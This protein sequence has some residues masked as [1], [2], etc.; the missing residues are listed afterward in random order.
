MGL[1]PQ[2]YASWVQ[3][4]LA[5][6]DQDWLIPDF[7]PA[8]SLTIIAGRPKY[9]AKSWISY[10]MAWAVSSGLPVGPFRPSRKVPCLYIDLEGIAKEAAKRVQLVRN[11][12]IEVPS[13]DL[14]DMWQAH[15]QL[16]LL[17]NAAHLDDLLDLVLTHRIKC[18]FI[19]TF[20]KA[21]TGADEN[22]ARD[23]GTVLLAIDRLKRAGVAVVLVHHL[24]K[25]F[26]QEG[27][28]SID[29]TAG[30][31]GSGALEGG[32]DHILSVTTATVDDVTQDYWVVGGKFQPWEAYEIDWTFKKDAYA[33]LAWQK[34]RTLPI[35][36]KPTRQPFRG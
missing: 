2:K 27:G 17:S 33:K 12:G 25:A 8:A 23:I 5:N 13:V 9:G 16:F 14:M 24:R 31:R 20:A 11:G 26:K 1:I 22:S 32:F 15:G 19:D 21:A 35:A 7:L 36:D 30:L 3:E 6:A 18:V 4:S 29:A 28:A 10:M 34:M